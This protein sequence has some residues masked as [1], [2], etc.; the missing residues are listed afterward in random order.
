VVRE[1]AIRFMLGGFIVSL[2]SLTGELWR[3]RSFSGIF[4]AAPSVAL[5][6]L[7]LAFSKEGPGTVS[8]LGRSMVIGAV[9]LFVYGAA[10]VFVTRNEKWPVWVSAFS[11]WI[12]WF[13]AA[14][15]GLGAGAAL[16]VLR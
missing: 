1:L 13:A 3:P 6:S 8:L 15:A 9:A 11:A 16:G 7:A 2:F 4:G 10:C 5:A 12:A 14:C